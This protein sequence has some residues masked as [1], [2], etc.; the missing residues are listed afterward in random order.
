[1]KFNDTHC[2]LNF[3]SFEEDF[4]DI[5]TRAKNQQV[6]K[7]MIPGTTVED[8]RLAVQ[9]SR[10]HSECFA[11]VGIH[12]NTAMEWGAETKHSIIEL[13]NHPEVYAIG[14]IGLDYYRDHTPHEIQKVALVEQ[15]QIAREAGKP[16]IIHIRD[17]IE[18]SFQILFSWQKKLHEENPSLAAC[19]GILHAFPGTLEEALQGIQHNFKIGVGGPVTFKNA[20]DRHSVVAQL[21]LSSIILETDAPFL[22]PHPHRGKRNEPS[23]I[24]LIAQKIAELQSIP[25]QEVADQ[26]TKNAKEV[27]QW[28]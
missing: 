10:G 8:S 22:T 15:L 23:Y 18:D 12:P 27:F 5:L 14:E 19:P 25:L 20:K 4:N 11:A 3:H 13:A 16:V 21:P 2:H 1:M 9:L 17:S 26:T 24:P 28:N 6:Q 7:I